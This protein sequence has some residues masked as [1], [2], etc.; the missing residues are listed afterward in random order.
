MRSVSPAGRNWPYTSYDSFS[1][2]DKLRTAATHSLVYFHFDFRDTKK[3]DLTALVAS[4]VFQLG[5]Q[6]EVCLAYLERKR[7]SDRPSYEQ[8]LAMLSH[9]LGLSGLTVLVIDAL[10][11]CPE[12]AREKGLKQFLDILRSLDEDRFRLMITSRP[13]PDIRKHISPRATHSL[14]FHDAVKHMED[15]RSHIK[16]KLS[17]SFSYDWSDDVRATAQQVLFEKSKGM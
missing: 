3:Q 9:L 15:L 7:S 17:D 5:T 14:S 6:S 8:L 4:L 13:E 16:T 11:E 2:V 12:P 1:I 10:D